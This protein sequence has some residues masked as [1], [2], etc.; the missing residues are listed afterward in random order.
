M[1]AAGLE[2]SACFFEAKVGV[3]GPV[4]F[5]PLDVAV[6]LWPEVLVS[7]LTTKM[8]NR[9]VSRT[10]KFEEVLKDWHRIV[11]LD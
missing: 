3:C 7:D 11:V 9:V 1:E 10:Q 6:G 2:G 8:I 4:D 5:V